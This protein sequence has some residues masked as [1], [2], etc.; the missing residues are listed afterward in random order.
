[1]PRPEKFFGEGTPAASAGEQLLEAACQVTDA[2]V[3]RA[4][5]E[6][7]REEWANAELGVGLGEH[8]DDRVPGRASR[9]L[10]PA[11]FVQQRAGLLGHRRIVLLARSVDKDGNRC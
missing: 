10:G 2:R 6:E 3:H 8:G 5:R 9:D 1:V 7:R 11:D 4:L